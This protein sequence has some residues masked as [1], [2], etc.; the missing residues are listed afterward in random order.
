MAFVC[1][2]RAPARSCVELNRVCNLYFVQRLWCNASTTTTKQGR[3]RR[4][5][6]STGIAVAV[7][8]S[9]SAG[10]L[11]VRSRVPPS[12]TVKSQVFRSIISRLV[13]LEAESYSLHACLYKLVGLGS[14]LSLLWCCCLIG[15][16]LHTTQHRSLLWCGSD[17]IQS[18]DRDRKR[19]RPL[20][21]Q[22]A[23]FRRH[24]RIQ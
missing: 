21:C 14:E 17:K 18:S 13:A 3:R 8:E 16:I 12:C 10:L 11:P 23:G 20:H 2:N 4:Q 9:S 1:P 22:P 6:H 5:W 24:G 19:E 15:Y 7:E